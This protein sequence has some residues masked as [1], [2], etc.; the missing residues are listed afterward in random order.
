[1]NTNPL[2]FKP[3]SELLEEQYKAMRHGDNLAP[4]EVPR[5][6]QVLHNLGFAEPI[7][8]VGNEGGAVSLRLDD[9]LGR[10]ANP[11]VPVSVLF[12]WPEIGDMR[13]QAATLYQAFASDIWTGFGAV[14]AV[15]RPEVT[16]KELR[17]LAITQVVGLD[18][19][20][21]QALLAAATRGL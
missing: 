20:F 11:E 12:T 3:V 19:A 17:E 6:L 14:A 15:L 5:L 16:A 18:K 10:G 1:M 13:A 8:T 4:R 9:Y 7:V 21:D 2:G